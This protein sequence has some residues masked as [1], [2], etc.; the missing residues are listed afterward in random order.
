MALRA[1]NGL[2]GDSSGAGLVVSIEEASSV[3][4]GEWMVNSQA[5]SYGPPWS[6]SIVFYL[7]H[8]F[9][10]A[11]RNCNGNATVGLRPRRSRR[12]LRLHAALCPRP[13][14]LTQACCSP[15]G[16][17][18]FAQ[19]DVRRR[20]STSKPEPGALGHEYMLRSAQGA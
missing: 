10:T 13:I 19:Q 1:L 11:S 4:L 14:S 9:G 5:N 6:Y 2:C 17:H 12:P 15:D 8:V 20:W 3:A 18:C 7:E 16:G